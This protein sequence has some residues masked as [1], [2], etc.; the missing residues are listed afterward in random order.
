MTGSRKILIVIAQHNFRDEEYEVPR[1]ILAK[2]HYEVQVASVHRGEAIG[3][4]GAKVWVDIPLVE[5]NVHNFA[6]VIFIGGQG[7][8][9]FFH[10][11]E[12]LNLAR[13]FEVEGKLVAAICIAPSILANAGLLKGKRA[14]AFSSEKE[15]MEAKGANYIAESVVADGKIITANGPDAAKEFGEKIVEILES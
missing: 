4:F 9:N 11:P 10:D 1:A 5:V 6:G 7:A 12:A 2:E 15:N 14:T 13:E 3:K 8:A